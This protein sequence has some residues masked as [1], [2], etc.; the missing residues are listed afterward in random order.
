MSCQTQS[1]SGRSSPFFGQ[2]RLKECGSRSFSCHVTS[3][4][5]RA[6]FSFLSYFVSSPFAVSLQVRFFSHPVTSRVIYSFLSNPIPADQGRFPLKI[7]PRCILVRLFISGLMFPGFLFLSDR[8]T[9]GSV[10]VAFPIKV[11]AICHLRSVSVLPD[12]F[13]LDPTSASRVH[14]SEYKK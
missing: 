8:L 1:V 3:V 11:F 13:L 2:I 5:I 6:G 14:D 7:Q 10:T 12:G 9:S 4:E